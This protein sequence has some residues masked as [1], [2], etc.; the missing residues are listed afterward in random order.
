MTDREGRG[1]DRVVDLSETQ[2]AELAPLA[3]G[4]VRVKV[5]W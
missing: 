4:V 2:F 3:V 5:S 1:S